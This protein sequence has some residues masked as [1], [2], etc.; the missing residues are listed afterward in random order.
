M[1]RIVVGSVFLVLTAVLLGAA[2]GTAGDPPGEVRVQGRAYEGQFNTF[3]GTLRLTCAPGLRVAALGLTFVQDFTSPESLQATTPT[4]DGA[5]HVVPYASYE[6]FHP[7]R[8]TVQ[9]RMALVDAATGAPAGEVTTGG[10]VYVRPGARVLLPRWV[11][12]ERGTI[13]ARV[14]GRC[15]EPWVL[16]DFFVAASQDEGFTFASTHLDIPCDGEW[17]ARTAVL[18]ATSGS[19]HRGRVYLDGHIA[20]LDAVNFDPAVFATAGR[21]AWAG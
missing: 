9:V 3:R 2:P 8:A 16:Q 20:T 10:S 7:G 21:W 5:W 14:A 12:H 18:T 13:R 4:C 19:L 11:D 17:H 1:R 6:G 15:D